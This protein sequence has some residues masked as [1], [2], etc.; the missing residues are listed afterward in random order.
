M[1]V[2]VCVHVHT[3]HPHVSYGAFPSVH[4]QMLVLYLAT[5][6]M[7]SRAKCDRVAARCMVMELL[8]L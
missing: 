7:P 1:C 3:E 2:Y 5:V 4:S 8:T 6:A